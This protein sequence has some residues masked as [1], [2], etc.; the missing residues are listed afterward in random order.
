MLC[1]SERVLR[2]KTVNSAI[3][4]KTIADHSTFAS[5]LLFS[6]YLYSMS[7]ICYI[8]IPFIKNIIK[9]LAFE[10]EFWVCHRMMVLG[11]FSKFIRMNYFS[12]ISYMKSLQVMPVLYIYTIAHRIWIHLDI[13]IIQTIIFSK[14]YSD[15]Y[16]F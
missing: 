8:S 9:N 1:S 15:H 4:V 7:N 11:N 3:H 6:V 2:Y 10:R 14:Y 16:V 13:S 5:H 12:Y